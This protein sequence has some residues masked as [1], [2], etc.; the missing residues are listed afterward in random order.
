MAILGLW[1]RPPSPLRPTRRAPLL[2]W[3]AGVLLTAAPA[4]PAAMAAIGEYQIKAIFVFN[5]AQFV[6]W[7]PAALPTGQSPLVIGVLGA[8]PFGAYLDEVVRGEKIEGHP[9]EVRR[10]GR[11]EDVNGC[12]I[13]FISQSEND[14]LDRILADLKGRSILTVSEA[15][16]FGA[17]G[18]MID[19]VTVDHKI[20]LRINVAAARA[21]TLTISSKLLRPAEIVATE[22]E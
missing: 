22:K 2:A 13:L 8:D 6:Q 1:P 9:L 10:Y 18:G 12:Q 3:L 16:G 15:S 4:L 19:M 17:R 7:P 20:R 14:R 5:F 11:I 21:S